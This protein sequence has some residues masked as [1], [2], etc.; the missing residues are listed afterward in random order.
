MHKE[1]SGKRNAHA[2]AAAELARLLSHC[3]R[4]KAKA[5]QNFSSARFCLGHI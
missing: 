2:P 5:M 4:S 1:C 3:R